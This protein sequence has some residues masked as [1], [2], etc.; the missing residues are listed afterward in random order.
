MKKYLWVI[1]LALTFPVTGWGKTPD[2]VPERTISLVFS[3]NVQ[4][5]L[6]PCG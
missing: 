3:S 5:E 1:L 2:V 6:E 4:G